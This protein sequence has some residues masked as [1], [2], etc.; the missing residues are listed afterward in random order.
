[1]NILHFD[2]P[3]SW[4]S[5]VAGF[6]RDRL[7][8]NPRLRLC[9]PAGH[10]PLPIYA[11]MG[12]AVRLEQVS[13][14]ETQ[15]FALDE[16]GGL[17]PDDPGGCANQLRRGLVEQ[18]DV[19]LFRFLNPSVA[20]LDRHCRDYDEAIGA[21]FDLVLLGVGLNGHLGLNEPG[22]APDSPSRRVALHA[23]SV[24]A[25]AQYLS[26]ARVP[27]W[28]LTVGL[29]QLLASKEVWLL[30]SGAAKAAI[31]RRVVRGAPDVSVPA[32]LLKRHSNCSVFVDA[33]AGRE[34]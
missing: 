11:A 30:A 31:L 33:E 24:K 5:G 22:S 2:S 19:Q 1:M 7:R 8:L 9:L 3:Q 27:T 32:S 6:W 28:G 16:Y 4:T 26:H 17:A 15:V 23:E 10:T 18:I 20:D 14:A 29:K 25:S 13:F 21:G 34:L 12:E